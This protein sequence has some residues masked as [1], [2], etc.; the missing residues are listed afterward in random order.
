[1]PHTPFGPEGAGGQGCA[2]YQQQRY[3]HEYSSIR[4]LK[5]PAEIRGQPK[6]PSSHQQTKKG[7]KCNLHFKPVLQNQEYKKR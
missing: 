4:S 6:R 5:P 7:P 2:S 1:V 3:F